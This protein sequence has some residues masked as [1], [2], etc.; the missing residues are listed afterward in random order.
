[1]SRLS[2]RRLFF[3][4]T[5]LVGSIYLLKLHGSLE[6]ERLNQLMD[7]IPRVELPGWFKPPNDGFRNSEM[8]STN[9]RRQLAIRDAMKHAWGGYRRFAFGE[10]ELQPLTRSYN[11]RWGNWSITLVDAL[12]TLYIMGLEDEYTE[13]KARVA[14][15]DFTTTL[16]G[17]EVPVFEM[18]IRA[19]GGLLGAYELENDPVLLRK[20]MEVGESLAIAFDTPTGLPTPRIDLQ[21]RI[22]MQSSSLC[23]AEGGT[24][25][26]EFKKLSQLTGNDTYRKLVERASDVLEEAPRKYRGLYP[27]FI[28]IDTGKYDNNSALSVGAMADSFYEYQL[29]QY[30]LHNYKESKYKDQYIVSSMAVKERLVARSP[31]S[32]RAFLGKWD[33][34]DSFFFSEMEHLACFYPGLLALGAHLLDRPR[35]LVLAEEIAYTCYL[36]YSMTPTGLGPEVFRFSS[37]NRP[38]NRYIDRPPPSVQEPPESSEMQGSDGR[39]LLRPETIESIFVLYRVTRDPKYQE[40]GWNIFL[41][42]EKYTKVEYGYAAYSDVYSTEGDNLVDSMESFFLAETL[43]YLYLLFSPTDLISL[44]EYVFNT[45]A[46]PFKIIK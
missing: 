26:L 24:L 16:P 45:E 22:P 6:S 8:T 25:Q 29:K 5:V 14:K 44:D 36:S 33:Y 9:H 32:N 28:D 10:D 43:K 19:L 20:A 12:D 37:L 21:K 3:L 7:N 35:D 2:F 18:T 41:A 39:Y 13:A 40:W 11:R 23:I 4:A 31:K 46:H 30:I 27:T 1:M 17:Y 38:Q 42:I 15:T 34:N